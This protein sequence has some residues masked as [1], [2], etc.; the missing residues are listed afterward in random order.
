MN[1]AQAKQLLRSF[2]LL[3]WVLLGAGAITFSILGGGNTYFRHG[4]TFSVVGAILGLMAAVPL[5]FVLLRRV[6]SFWRQDW[7]RLGDG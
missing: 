3:T 4:H 1:Q 7:T 6:F 5:I 2:G